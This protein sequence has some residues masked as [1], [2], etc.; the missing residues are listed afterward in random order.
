M[1]VNSSA[2]LHARL[3]IAVAVV[4][5]G[6]GCVNVRYD[7][8]HADSAHRLRQV[9]YRFN[10]SMQQGGIGATFSDVQFCYDQATS[11]LIARFA[12]Q[13]CLVY[14]YAVFTFEMAAAKAFHGSPVPLYQPSVAGPR[15]EKY[16]KLD[17][18]ADR[19]ET[20]VFAIPRATAV[21]NDLQAQP[22]SFL[23]VGANRRPPLMHGGGTF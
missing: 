21:L 9:A 2:S 4:V 20:V 19:N 15:F 5:G 7:D 10:S 12:L 13:D 22:G 1:K 3:A 11:P 6:S 8:E 23:N 14:D 16:G 17:G 18:F